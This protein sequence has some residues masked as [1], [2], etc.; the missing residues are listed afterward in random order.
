[1]SCMYAEQCHAPQVLMLWA[2]LSL[3]VRPVSL[4]VDTWGYTPTGSM[5]H[6]LP[7]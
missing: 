7:I 6:W 1:M 2:R 3:M 5:V 4:V